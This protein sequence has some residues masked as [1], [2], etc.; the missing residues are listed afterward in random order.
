MRDKKIVMFDEG[1][2]F[3]PHQINY[4]QN[5]ARPARSLVLADKEPNRSDYANNRKE[6]H[7]Q[8]PVI[9]HDVPRLY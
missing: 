6:S 1:T 8:I 5:L 4:M 2:Q 7:D 3:T 9:N